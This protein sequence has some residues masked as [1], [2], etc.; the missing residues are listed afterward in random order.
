MSCYALAIGSQICVTDGLIQKGVAENEI[1]IATYQGS[2]PG[3][4]GVAGTLSGTS[5]QISGAGDLTQINGG[6]LA[7][8]GA[9]GGNLTVQ[10]SSGSQGCGAYG[11]S[12]VSPGSLTLS[13]P[14]RVVARQAS[15]AVTI[16]ASGKKPFTVQGTS[17]GF[18][19]QLWPMDGTLH[20]VTYQRW[21]YPAD[22]IG[23]LRGAQQLADYVL[24]PIPSGPA[25]GSLL[26]FPRDDGADSEALDS[27]FGLALYGPLGYPLEPDA[28][29][30]GGIAFDAGLEVAPLPGASWS[31][32]VTNGVT[33]LAVNPT[34]IDPQAADSVIDGMAAYTDLDGGGVPHVYASFRGGN[35]LIELV[36][37]DANSRDLFVFH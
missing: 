16:V 12:A 10:L 11:I 27:V 9:D 33:P 6:L 3:L 26:T 1:L 4:A 19:N 2:L 5:L 29:V 32:N 20:F 7:S 28:G 35:A 31:F 34:G 22:L 8:E 37:S 15:V 21:Q 13:S 23:M 14:R 36:P 18:Q 17:I 24:G 30:D 25:P